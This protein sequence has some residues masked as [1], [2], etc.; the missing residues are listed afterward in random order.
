MTDDSVGLHS[1][2]FLQNKNNLKNFK[3]KFTTKKVVGKF[4]FSIS[5]Y[6]KLVLATFSSLFLT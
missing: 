3:D 5:K 2:L 4:V 1:I 6:S